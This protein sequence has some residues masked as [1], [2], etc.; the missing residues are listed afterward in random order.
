MY[1]DSAGGDPAGS[2]LSGHVLLACSR[3]AIGRRVE[4]AKEGR[5]DGRKYTDVRFDLWR[6][7]MIR[8]QR[9][10]EG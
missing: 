5:K 7:E 4:W 1:S 10:G 2:Y 8:D 9:A 6:D 3:H